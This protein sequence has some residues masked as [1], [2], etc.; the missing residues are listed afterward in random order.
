MPPSCS[1][2]V[3][4]PAGDRDS[5]TGTINRNERLIGY[6]LPGTPSSRAVIKRI[7][8]AK[9]R[10]FKAVCASFVV[11]PLGDSKVRP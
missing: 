6:R 5:G 1:G 4:H 8:L 2:T 7:S 9:T 11:N 3:P 10:R